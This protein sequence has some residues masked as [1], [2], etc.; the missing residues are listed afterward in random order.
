[1]IA[2]VFSMPHTKATPE[3]ERP[4]L[5]QLRQQGGALPQ[6]SV[7]IT[8]NWESGADF[9]VEVFGD[10]DDVRETIEPQRQRQSSYH[11][12]EKDFRY[13]NSNLTELGKR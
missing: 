10:T 11:R 1:M 4:T 12:S 8:G 9:T 7:Q 6:I 13:V 3:H 5:D 2:P